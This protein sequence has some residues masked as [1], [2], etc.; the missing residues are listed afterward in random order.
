MKGKTNTAAE[1]R[2]RAE[3]RLRKQ[4][5]S[6]A[7]PLTEADTQRLLHELQVHQI[8]LEMQNAELQEA[9]DQM[10]AML[11]KYT[12]LYDF[13]PVGYFSLDEQ[14]L[15][16]EVNLTGA[17]LLGVERSQLI[18][19]RLPQLVTPTSR[20]VLLAFLEKVF[21]GPGRQVCEASL[22][23]KDGTSFWAN[24]QAT[25][26]NSLTG[27]RNWCR[28]AVSDI[29]ALKRAEEAQRRAEAVDA[30]NRELKQEIVRRKEV[31]KA[32]KTSERYSRRLLARALELQKRLQ[33]LSHQVLEA[34]E[35]ERKRI[36]R[37][38]HDEIAQVLTAVNFH[39]AALKKEAVPNDKD[40][41]RRIARTQR[42]VGRSVDIVHQFAGQLR[43]AALDDLGL[44][45][46]LRSYANGFAK[47]AGLT[48]HFTSFTRDRTE[49]LDSDKRTV[50][51]R[52]VQEALCNVAKHA[53]ASLVMVSVRKL[54]DVVCVEV[55]DDGKS[56]DVRGVLSSKRNKGLGLL[57]MRERVEMVG[58]RFSVESAPGKGTTIRAAIPFAKGRQ[59]I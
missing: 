33:H 40:F 26:A 51:Y 1:L 13:A 57:G 2:R 11:E 5:R 43:P 29:S 23:N 38:L 4:H 7:A 42:L 35:E 31:E 55:R 39:L 22:L 34:Q 32:L 50:L 54:R 52:V 53:C 36:S 19:R 8:E 59:K 17:A 48:V 46:A 14:G 37:E 10:E 27:E 47:R 21:A 20:P 6:T 3:A 44:V 45:P 49:L 24:L 25:S 56:F 30:A 28:M 41:R 16:R 58:G 9:R 12:D 18:N 15:I